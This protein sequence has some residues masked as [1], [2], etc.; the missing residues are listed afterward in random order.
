MNGKNRGERQYA[1]EA[2][3]KRRSDILETAR[4]LLT[5]QEGQFTMRELAAKSGVALATLYNIFGNQKELIGQA[6]IEVLRGSL[7]SWTVSED[8]SLPE[9]VERRLESVVNE[10]FRR[11][12]YARKM[13]E[14]YFLPDPE[15][16]VADLLHSVSLEDVSQAIIRL[17]ERNV[18][19]EDSDPN[20]IAR[21]MVVIQYAVIARWSAGKFPDEQLLIRLK[22]VTL[23]HLAGSLV[24]EL[25]KDCRKRMSE[26][27]ASL[28]DLD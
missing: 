15:G 27:R 19:A 13:A 11:P 24:P 9:Q 18:L 28:G 6:V 5:E 20:L 7:T 1:S 16:V 8:V 21:E 12:A 14:L 3:A 4:L 17:A 10:I 26:L 23:G 22:H 25:A 2:M